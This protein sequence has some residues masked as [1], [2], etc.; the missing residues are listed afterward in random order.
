MLQAAC[1]RGLMKRSTFGSIA[2]ACMVALAC[3]GAPG[4]EQQPGNPMPTLLG[5]QFNGL[6][7]EPNPSG[8]VGSSA[9]DRCTSTS[10]ELGAGESCVGISIATESL[11][12][13]I[14][15]MFDQSGSMCSCLDPDAAQICPNPDCSETR[16]DAIRQ[17]TAAFLND[18]DSADIGVGLGRFGSQPIGEASCEA[19]DH[20]QPLVTLGLLPEHAPSIMQALNQLQPVGETPTGAAIRGACSYAQRSREATPGR[21]VVLLLVT[22]GR[23]EAP[24]SCEAGTCCP[25]LD[26]AVSAAEDCRASSDIDTYVLG[27]GPFLSN[28][29]QIASAGGTEHAYLVEGTDVSRRV[30]EALN[31]IRSDAAIPCELRLPPAPGGQSLALDRVN[32]VYEGAR[33]DE[34][35]LYAVPSAAD[36][37]EEDGWHYDNPSAPSSILLCPRSCGRVAA[38]GGTLSYSIGCD[39]QTLIR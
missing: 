32:L 39:T 14:H 34:T 29:D 23:P 25:S 6:E 30:L 10:S 18:R 37:G 24:V 28:L 12:L 22:D 16:L 3:G 13:D 7:P 2:V 38:P 33:C 8:S 27:V 35:L 17:A 11:P 19:A 9:E 21:R 15:I 5:P 20:A 4:A 1:F 26:D 36:C 31:R